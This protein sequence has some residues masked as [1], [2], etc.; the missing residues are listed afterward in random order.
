M[1]EAIRVGIGCDVHRFKAGRKLV[2]GGVEIPHE[3]GLDGHSDA[4]VLLHAVCDALLGAAGMGDIGR[5]FPPSDPAYKDISSVLL[6]AEVVRR[7]HEAGFVVQNVDA[8]VVAEAPKL[9]P[10]APAMRQRMAEV[11]RVGEGAVSV[12]ATTVEG[13]GWIGA[14]EGM[15]AIAVATVARRP[16]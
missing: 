8:T 13:L 11:L 12:K 14:G 16:S 5:L 7:L 15:A 6:L 3:A 1:N 9:A 2:L 4:D 10:H